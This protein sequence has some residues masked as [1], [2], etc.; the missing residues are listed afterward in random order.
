MAARLLGILRHKLLQLGFRD[1]ML[2]VG[3]SGAQIGCRK[4]RPQIGRSHVD[5]LDGLQPRTR[6]FDVEQ[7]RRLAALDAA[8][9][10]LLSREQEMLIERVGMNLDL[11][12]FATAGDDRKHR[13]ARGDH[14]HI[15]LELCHVLFGRGLFRE[16]P[17]QHEL[18][19]E[20]RACRLDH[21]IQR[22]RHPFVHGMPNALLDVRDGLSC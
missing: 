8:P 4:L 21:A 3:L 10:L 14:P 6:R 7:E 19:L 17:R 16:S 15:V 20:H 22:C 11:D 5:D 1:L 2:A 9:E 12:P 18:G 13:R